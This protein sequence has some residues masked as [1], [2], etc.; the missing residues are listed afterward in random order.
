MAEEYRQPRYSRPRGATE[1]V[2]LRHGESRA[3][4]ADRP[5]PLIGGQGDPELHPTGH[6]QAKLAAARLCELPISAVYVTNLR[7]TLET[8]APLCERLALEPIVEPDLREV[9]LGAWEGGLY[10]IKARNADP[11][12]LQMLA[13]QRWDVIPG[14]ESHASLDRRINSALARIAA[15]HPDRMV[16]AVVHGGVIG[17]ILAHASGAQRF[18]FHGAD[19][20]SISHI[21]MTENRIVIRCFNDTSHLAS[22]AAGH[23]AHLT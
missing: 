22:L 17:H 12:Y 3:A 6:E 10:R 20:G 8:A 1:I 7:R 11:V 13:E 16:V 5:F 21:V 23:A 15:R 9:H 4:T 2:L 19:N 18:A 14:A